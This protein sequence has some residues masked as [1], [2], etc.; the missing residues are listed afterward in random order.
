M[1]APDRSTRELLDSLELPPRAQAAIEAG[2]MWRAKEIL[3]SRLV[4]ADLAPR[5]YEQYGAILLAM[6]D[7][8][9]AGRY[10]FAS[11]AR[12]PEYD[13]AIDLFLQRYSRAGRQGLMD[14]LPTHARY[15]PSDQL[16]TAVAQTL[17]QLPAPPP[18]PVAPTTILTRMRG[19]MMT[20]YG[21]AVVLFFGLLVVLGIKGI[22]RGLRD[23]ILP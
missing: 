5:S 19:C 2:Q 9:I 13:V 3:Q 21:V 4:N 14:V 18:R 6:G 7:L 17:E 10:L 20:I 22:L 15:L 23:L 16:P 8:M 11:G 12:R 1:T